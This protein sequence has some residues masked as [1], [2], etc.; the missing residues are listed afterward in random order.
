MS[1]IILY[2]LYTSTDASQTPTAADLEALEKRQDRLEQVLSSIIGAKKMIGHDTAWFL[3]EGKQNW[4]AD[5]I[6]SAIIS[7]ARLLNCDV[8]TVAHIS[9]GDCAPPNTK[10]CTPAIENENV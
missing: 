6:K 1:H 5:R 4:R 8:V 10:W 3:P 2:T 7:H 9:Q